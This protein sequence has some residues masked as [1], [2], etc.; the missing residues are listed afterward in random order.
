MHLTIRGRRRQHRHLIER[1]RQPRDSIAR[2]EDRVVLMPIGVRDEGA[3]RIEPAQAARVFI[4]DL[5]LSRSR[6]AARAANQP[7]RR[8]S[9]RDSPRPD[10]R[11]R[12]R[13]SKRSLSRKQWVGVSTMW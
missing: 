2:K 1:R 6:A 8:G 4:A 11:G 3:E 9:R 10:V 12:R 13:R 5:P 7:D